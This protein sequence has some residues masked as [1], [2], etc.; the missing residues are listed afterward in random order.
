LADFMRGVERKAPP[1]PNAATARKPQKISDGQWRHIRWLQRQL[2][3]DDSN[4][5]SYVQK[6]AKVDHE[7]FLT[8]RLAKDVITGMRSTLNYRS[9]R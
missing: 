7:R 6:V 1:G 5:R 9:Y 8:V 2:C 4:L 3:W